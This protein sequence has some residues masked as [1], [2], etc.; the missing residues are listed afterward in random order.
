[1]TYRLTV[2]FCPADDG[3]ST[4]G[5]DVLRTALPA[6]EAAIAAI[7]QA[8]DAE[9]SPT[10]TCAEFAD[11]L[12]HLSFDGADATPIERLVADLAAGGGPLPPQAASAIRELQYALPKG[13]RAVELT[14]GGCNASVPSVR[15]GDG[16]AIW[17]GEFGALLTH[18]PQGGKPFV[19]PTDDEL[20]SNVEVE[21]FNRMVVEGRGRSK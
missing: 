6:V 18:R 1:M 11:P 17:D 5:A 20:L 19:W 14:Y 4:V 9:C 10:L 15:H 7:C 13:I 3:P 2:R 21:A 8:S 12:M 16:D